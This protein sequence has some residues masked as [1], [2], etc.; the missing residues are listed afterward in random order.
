MEKCCIFTGHR[1]IPAAKTA[2]LEKL[3]DHAV[4]SVWR[5]GHTRFVS[6]GAMGFDLM[7][8][9]AVL[10]F[11]IAH[12][13]V[14]L[15]LQLP[16]PGYDARFSDTDHRRLRDIIHKA[17]E[18]RWTAEFYYDDCY[19]ARDRAMVDVADYCLCYLTNRR[20]G[21]GYTVRRCLEKG[22]RTTNL[23]DLLKEVQA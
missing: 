14:K 9:E 8:A 20:S 16:F 10:R 1:N 13:E 7:A 23:A 3:L 15:I 2:A 17:D 12:P 21:T 18:C 4:E 11:R 22:V 6:G 5:V 19:L